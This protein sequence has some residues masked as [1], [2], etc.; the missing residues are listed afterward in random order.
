MK[1]KQFLINF[2][3]PIALG[4]VIFIGIVW[5]ILLSGCATIAPGQDALAVNAERLET[6]SK[7]AFDE[8]TALDDLN[9]DFWRTNAPEFHKFCEWIRTPVTIVPTTPNSAPVITV[10]TNVPIQYRRGRAMIKLVDDAKLVYEANKA[11]SN[12][13]INMVFDLQSAY[14]QANSWKVI[15]QSPTR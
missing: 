13:L 6:V 10:S 9:R 1:T 3:Y 4:I 14:N 8:V 15:V 7:S 11:Q 5:M 2:G 12:I